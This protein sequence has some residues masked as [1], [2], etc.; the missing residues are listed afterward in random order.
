[1]SSH[2]II[3]ISVEPIELCKLLKIANMVSGGG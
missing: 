3:D 1:M 2:A